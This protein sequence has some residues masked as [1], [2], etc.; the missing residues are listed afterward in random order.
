[1][2][3]WS[4][5][6]SSGCTSRHHQVQAFARAISEGP[7]PPREPPP[8]SRLGV[9]GSP[10][11]GSAG[12]LAGG[13]VGRHLAHGEARGLLHGR[14]RVVRLRQWATRGRRLEIRS[15]VRSPRDLLPAYFHFPPKAS[16][17]FCPDEGL[18][19]GVL[20]IAQVRRHAWVF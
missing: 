5:I 19:E 3:P 15:F 17:N 10:G 9:E 4:T 12:I 1:M 14:R 13:A 20:M 7:P 6:C 18:R 11:R 16:G 2:P 8:R